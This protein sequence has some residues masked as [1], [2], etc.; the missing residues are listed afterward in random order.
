MACI[1]KLYL[2]VFQV[3][4]PLLNFINAEI[5]ILLETFMSKFVKGREIEDADNP[6]KI[7]KLNALESVNH[8]AASEIDIGLE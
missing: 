4:T 8:E 2:Q 7:A 1:M 3:D 5:K 6:L